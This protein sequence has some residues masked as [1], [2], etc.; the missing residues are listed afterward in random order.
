MN[1]I[2]Y[3]IKLCII[4]IILFFSTSIIGAEKTICY[5]SFYNQIF[6]PKE[7]CSRHEDFE[8]KYKE[9]LEKINCQSD[10]DRPVYTLEYAVKIILIRLQ[11]ENKA[12][13]VIRESINNE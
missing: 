8:K 12:F 2:K 6:V 7:E 5:R 3:Q 4:V 9:I 11:G 10:G 1:K 13:I